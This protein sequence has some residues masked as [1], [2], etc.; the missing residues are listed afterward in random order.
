ML[1]AKGTLIFKQKNG[2]QTSY[3]L[4]NVKKLTFSSG[5]IEINK[6]DGSTDDYLLNDIQMLSFNA[7][8]DEILDS[9]LSNGNSLNLYPNPASEMLTID[10]YVSNSSFVCI[11]ILDM[12]GLN[13]IQLSKNSLCGLNEI[14]LDVEKLPAGIYVCRING[15]GILKTL[16]F[17]KSS[18]K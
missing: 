2:M 16:K 6:S 8:A 9:K 11:E 7:K 4:S 10:Y 1:L 18:S 5:E 12:K 15:N 17:V 3:E 13:M 14:S